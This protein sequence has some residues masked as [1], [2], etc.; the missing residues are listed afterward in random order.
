M[1]KSGCEEG[2]QGTD[3]RVVESFGD[4]IYKK[5]YKLKK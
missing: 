1:K 2:K 5:K 4:Y 3:K